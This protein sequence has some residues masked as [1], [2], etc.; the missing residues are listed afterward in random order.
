MKA[1]KI[2]LTAGNITGVPEMRSIFGNM[3]NLLLAQD[4][5]GVDWRHIYSEYFQ[6]FIYHIPFLLGQYNT[7]RPQEGYLAAH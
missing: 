5:R 6:S 1:V 7:W 3:M 2:Y 4:T